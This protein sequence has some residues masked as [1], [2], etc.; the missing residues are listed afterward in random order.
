MALEHTTLS[1]LSCIFKGKTP[2]NTL[3]LSKMGFGTHHLGVENKTLHIKHVKPVLRARVAQSHLAGI[4]L[5]C[6]P[7]HVTVG[8]FEPN[9][10]LQQFFQ[11]LGRRPRQG[12][13]TK[14]PPFTS[15]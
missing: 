14:G 13:K 9:Q 7:G 10:C 1:A 5:S 8:G 4:S 3:K 11:K 15:N 12:V 6:M 2:W